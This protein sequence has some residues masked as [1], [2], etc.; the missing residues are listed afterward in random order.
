M[1][2][3]KHQ[4]SARRNYHQNKSSNNFNP[5]SF[6]QNTV[7]VGQHGFFVTYCASKESF[8]RNEIY[9][10]LNR[11]ADQLFGSEFSD[12]KELDTT[13]LNDLDSALENEKTKLNDS[14]KT[15]RRF[16]IVKSG[17]NHSFFVTTTLP[18]NSINK[19]IELIFNT[20][21]QTKEQHSRY[22][23][24]LLPILFICKAYEDDL[25]KTIIKK[26]FLEQILLF[27]DE[28]DSA[29]NTIWF[30]VQAK[31]SNNT[32]LKSSHLEEIL[33]N[34][35]LS[36]KSED[37]NGKI[38]KRDYKKPQIHILIHVIKNIMLISIVR[39]YDV[40]KKYNLAS[41][42]LA[43]TIAEGEGEQQQQQQQNKIIFDDNN[44]DDEEK[45]D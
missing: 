8:V 33:I 21:I 9:N 35:L 13:D 45:D 32:Q 2:R 27:S 24:R 7:Q 26:E 15:I 41:I 12:E 34:D 16:Q 25:R 14:K 44:D 20:S 30:D 11:F 31:K 19:L 3:V 42:N 29:I 18:L 43:T 39:N 38:F 22:V 28:N 4:Q 6:N 1:G 36:R 17:T 37:L 10:L 5:H 23:E 40:F